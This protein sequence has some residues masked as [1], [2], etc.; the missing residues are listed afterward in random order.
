MSNS[1]IE[2]FFFLKMEDKMFKDLMIEK[3][4]TDLGRF[5]GSILFLFAFTPLLLISLGS[6]FIVERTVCIAF[7]KAFTVMP[8]TM[9]IAFAL[10][11][12]LRIKWTLVV[13]ILS[14]LMVTGA[15][16]DTSNIF[17]AELRTYILI[18]IAIFIFVKNTVTFHNHLNEYSAIRKQE[19]KEEEPE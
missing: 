8:I 6:P 4:E 3:L 7:I 10:F 18:T 2:R 9:L 13:T 19:E 16:L 15:G 11:S 12:D 17:T 14:V 1:R 5:L